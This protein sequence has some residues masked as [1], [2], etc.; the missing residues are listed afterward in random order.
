MKEE[1]IFQMIKKR[2]CEQESELEE[3]LE[4]ENRNGLGN[5]PISQTQNQPRNKTHMTD[6][7]VNLV[8]VDI[9]HKI[10]KNDLVRNREVESE[11]N[12]DV[13][14]EEMGNIT[15]DKEEMADIKDEEVEIETASEIN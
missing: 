2:D 6:S 7:L 13:L 15:G 1:K 14:G 4:N 9:E 10:E 12:A 8:V 3:E 11:S 5:K